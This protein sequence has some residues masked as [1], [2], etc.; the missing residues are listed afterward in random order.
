ML[1]N[2]KVLG[3]Y[4]LP[5]MIL[6]FS[7]IVGKTIFVTIGSLI[8]GQPLKQSLQSGMSLS[9][10]GE[11]S[12]IIATLGVSLGA[13]SDFLYPIAVGVS[14]ITTFTTPYMMRLAEP[15]ANWLEGKLPEKLVTWLNR[16]SSGAQTL[17]AESEWRVVLRSYFTLI[18]INSVVMVGIVLLSTRVLLPFLV[19][20]IP[21]PFWRSVLVAVIGLMAMSPFLW[22]LAG[23]KMHNTAYTNLWLDKKYNRG[24][25]VM[26]EVLRVTLAVFLVGFLLDQVFSTRIAFIV[27]IIVILLVGIVFSRRLQA[28][29]SV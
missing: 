18:L 10:I 23:K 19:Q 24:P 4:A 29:T 28:F 22:A 13:T 9:Q 7:V 17:N 27:S 25:L 3:E 15:L 6:T 8:S 1:I 14:V 2:V 21:D 26:L 5:V 16:Y 12:F 11:F 20:H